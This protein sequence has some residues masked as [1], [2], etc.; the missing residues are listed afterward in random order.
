MVLIDRYHKIPWH[1][2]CNLRVLRFGRCTAQFDKYGIS[3]QLRFYISDRV[4]LDRQVEFTK[5]SRN[6]YLTPVR[7]S[8]LNNIKDKMAPTQNSEWKPIWDYSFVGNMEVSFKINR[9]K[10]NASSTLGVPRNFLTLN[11]LFW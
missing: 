11:C 10:N 9:E 8:Y 1:C 6:P 3:S 2:F 5:P 7:T 4:L